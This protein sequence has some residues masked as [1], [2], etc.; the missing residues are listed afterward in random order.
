MDST[1]QLQLNDRQLK[2]L[3]RLERD[4]FTRLCFRLRR[5]P[6]EYQQLSLTMA[7]RN[8]REF[9]NGH[10]YPEIASL[11]FSE[12]QELLN[13][14][15]FW[16]YKR[17]QKDRETRSIVRHICNNEHALPINYEYLSGLCNHLNIST[18]WS[19]DSGILCSFLDSIPVVIL[20]DLSFNAFV[21]QRTL[22]DG[23]I[24][25]VCMFDQ[26]FVT[27][28]VFID[29]VLAAA[30]STTSGMAVPTNHSR[31]F[32]IGTQPA[33]QEELK[34]CIELVLGMSDRV[35]L[36]YDALLRSRPNMMLPFMIMTH[37]AQRFVWYHEYGHLLMGHLPVGPC[38]KVEFAA[39]LFG[40]FLLNHHFDPADIA[41]FWNFL[42][43]LVVMLLIALLEAILHVSESKTHPS[44]RVRIRELL[45]TLTEHD[46]NTMLKF[47]DAVV[48]I[49]NPTLAR[50][51][52]VS[53]YL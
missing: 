10:E 30:I 20:F 4:S 37:G 36:I 34:Q 1:P 9:I 33:F 44:A 29:F 40:W 27:S 42:G 25:C 19:D 43:A 5:N 23:A 7:Q 48:S 31:C 13:A 17:L 18:I 26:L 15:D 47:L 21:E 32:E 39:D 3:S 49:C 46:R 45:A 16:T 35:D 2:E 12:T 41:A 11:H 52:N 22:V 50:Y 8:L 6:D 28:E 14:P 24:P 51:W 38:H 53:L